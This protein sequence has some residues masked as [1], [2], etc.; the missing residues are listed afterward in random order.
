MSESNALKSPQ[1]RKGTMNLLIPSRADQS[2]E[3]LSRRGL[4]IDGWN[5]SGGS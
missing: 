4:V 3:V 2:Q 1:A 5:P